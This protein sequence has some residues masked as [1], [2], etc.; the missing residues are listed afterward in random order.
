M[1]LRIRDQLGIPTVAGHE[2]DGLPGRGEDRDKIMEVAHSH[3]PFS[4]AMPLYVTHR[5][6]AIKRQAH[7]A[8]MHPQ[9]RD[10]LLDDGLK[11]QS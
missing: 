5:H 7:L 9:S 4:L 3:R 8:G 11:R 2:E 6:R 10:E 1:L